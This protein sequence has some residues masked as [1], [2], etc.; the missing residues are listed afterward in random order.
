MPLEIFLLYPRNAYHPPST[1][2]MS[3]SPP[4]TTSSSNFE[5]IFRA[6]LEAYKKKTKDIA[7]HP[8]A[9]QL[10]SCDSPGAILDLLQAQ[11]Q[12]FDK[13]QS[14]DENLKKW[15]DPTVNVLCSFSAIL[16]GGVGL[17]ITRVKLR[18]FHS[19]TWLTGIPTCECDFY[20]NRCSP[21]GEHHR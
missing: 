2:Q 3:Q 1:N 14:A 11:A 21:P 5:E 6:S 16:G 19:L 9:N 8:L 12:A 15:L 7:S 17:V 4:S 10:Q 20:R 13:S 18:G